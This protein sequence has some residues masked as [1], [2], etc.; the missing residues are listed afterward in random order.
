MWRLSHSHVFFRAAVPEPRTKDHT[1]GPLGPS[2]TV[3]FFRITSKIL[4]FGTWN[5]T[6][7]ERNIK[8][9]F[10]GISA[11]Y[12]LIIEDIHLVA[13]QGPD[14]VQQTRVDFNIQ[15]CDGRQRERRLRSEFAFFQSF[16]YSYPF[17]LSNVGG[18]SCSWIPRDNIQVQKEKEN[19]VVAKCLRY[20]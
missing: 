11:R 7:I 15:R 1:C 2:S 20:Q 16:N 13:H 10:R 12:D 4:K 17:T 5:F 8:V 19:F 18:P 9:T 14:T 6:I 3:A